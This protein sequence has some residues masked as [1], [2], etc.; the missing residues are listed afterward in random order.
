[1]SYLLVL[2]CV[3][4]FTTCG[5]DDEAVVS[6]KDTPEIENLRAAQL[7]DADVYGVTP[8]A[9]A[10][11]TRTQALAQQLNV[12]LGNPTEQEL[13]NLQEAWIATSIASVQ[14]EMYD[15]SKSRFITRLVVRSVYPSAVE[16]DLADPDLVLDEDFFRS[17][18]TMPYLEYLLFN[19]EPAEVLLQIQE[20]TRRQEALVAAKDYLGN[21]AA[22]FTELWDSQRDEVLNNLG[23]VPNGGQNLLVNSL[24]SS[25]R[26]TVVT[27][28]YNP[29]GGGVENGEFQAGLFEAFYSKKSLELLRASWQEWKRVFY[30]DYG[31]TNTT[32]GFDDYLIALEE[33]QLL[34]NIDEAV[35]NFDDKLN[36]L[37]SI[38][39]DLINNPSRLEETVE[40][41]AEVQRYIRLD[42]IT[43]LCGVLLID[44]GCDY[45]DCD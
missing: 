33:E 3:L 37:T 1:M 6:L 28:L 38:Q 45:G 4:L 40:A 26:W 11:T 22:S 42:L 7:A 10:L 16:E 25:L 8:A 41:L 29:I 12:F 2:S 23:T 21:Q 24:I 27:R 18:K 44:D 31:A 13:I 34:Q 17:W 30:A 19:A 39:D 5:D 35:L 20:D 36:Q 9:E 14:F 32:I 15:I 43:A